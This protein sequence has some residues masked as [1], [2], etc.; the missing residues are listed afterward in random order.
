METLQRLVEEDLWA[1]HA[2]SA[3][4]RIWSWHA[5]FWPCLQQTILQVALHVLCML[6][7]QH[8]NP[9]NQKN[10]FDKM[11]TIVSLLVYPIFAT[12]AVIGSLQ[13]HADVEMR[14]YGTSWWSVTFLAM[15][16]AKATV[17]IVVLCF[18]DLSTRHRNLM[19]VHHILS[20]ACFGNALGTGRMHFFACFAAVCEITNIPLS[21]LYFFKAIGFQ[22]SK[23]GMNHAW[24]YIT[25]GAMLFAT[26]VMFRLLLFPTW[27]WLFCEDILHEPEETW[28]RCSW[29][30]GCF[31]P[32]VA[33]FLFVLSCFWMV[34][35]S[36]G[37]YKA[38]MSPLSETW[39][40]S[41]QG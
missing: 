33:V 41:Q 15:Y 30:E 1:V 19:I 17:H 10:M 2:H 37:L 4:D 39:E 16:L 25:N 12:F 22:S 13:L 3:A 6:C 36:A 40:P 29:L 9:E 8:W 28:A 14:W 11:D 21:I 23:F 7:V 32:T 18:Q 27:L 5:C 31:Y 24:L 38:I 26:F 20:M 35:I 34:P